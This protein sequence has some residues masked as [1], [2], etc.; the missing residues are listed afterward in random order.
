MEFIETLERVLRRYPDH[1]GACHYYIHAVEAWQP[2]RAVPCAE[3]LPHLASGAGHLVH[4]PAHI[5]VRLGRYADA[6]ER[7]RQ[8]VS[9]DRQYLEGRTLSGIYPIGYYPHNIH[10]LWAAL[11]MQGRS[12]EAINAARELRKAVP[13]TPCATLPRSRP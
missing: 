6:A 3:R 5:Y 4:M 7:N 1:L 11:T 10:F 12:A 8:E 13:Q 2:E 9:T